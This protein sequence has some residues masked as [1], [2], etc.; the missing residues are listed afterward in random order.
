MS[1]FSNALKAALESDGTDVIDEAIDVVPGAD[2]GSADGTDDL[3]VVAQDD[4]VVV[5]TSDSAEESVA[6]LDD[7]EAVITDTDDQADELEE[8]ATGLESIYQA[9]RDAARQ[10]PLSKD[11]LRFANIGI[12]SYTARL[13]LGGNLALSTEGRGNNTISLEGLKETIN[14]AWEAIKRLAIRIWVA[15]VAFV[16]RLFSTAERLEHRGRKLIELAGK[17]G[18]AAPKNAEVELKGLASKI[19][20]GKDIETNPA[21][22]IAVLVNLANAAGEDAARNLQGAK[23]CMEVA[24]L[25]ARGDVSATDAAARLKK[26]LA[27]GNEVGKFVGKQL[28]GNLKLTQVKKSLGFVEILDVNFV[29]DGEGPKDGKMKTMGSDQIRATGKAAIDAAKAIKDVNNEANKALATVKAF[30]KVELSKDLSKEQADASRDA[31]KAFRAATGGSG[32]IIARAT[33]HLLKTGLA[34]VQVAEK[35]AAQYSAKAKT[36]K[37]DDKKAA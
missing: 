17:L 13:G 30:K 37:K 1:R 2:T 34:Y 14:K 5:D 10:K 29:A 27:G 36:E 8:A 18:S 21:N 25:A 16:K 9:L 12:E 22:G 19:A 7:A 11:T 6:E 33:S 24:E 23:E 15:I 28:P 31:Q 32:R 20:V 3:A 26:A 4:N 35:S